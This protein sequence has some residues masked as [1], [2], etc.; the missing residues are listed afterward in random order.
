MPSSFSWLDYSEAE[1]RRALDVADSFK[2]RDTRDELGI[3]TV[4]DAL[5]NILFPGTTTIQTR[6]RYFLFIPWIYLA[7]EEKLRRRPFASKEEVAKAARREEI[8]LI[9]VLLDSDDADGTI[10]AEAGATLKRLPSNI[11]WY[12]MGSWGIRKAEASQDQ[13]HR[14]LATAGA[15]LRIEGRNK[16]DG[17][18]ELRSV[19]NWHPALHSLRPDEFPQKA[20]FTLTADES[21][22]LKE[23][24]KGKGGRNASMLAVLA[25]S[26]K[27]WDDVDFAWEHEVVV[28]NG[29]PKQLEIA[30]THARNFSEIMHGAALLY[31]LMLAKRY[32]ELF[33]VWEEKIE[34]YQGEME[35]WSETMSARKAA[36]LDW[37]RA[38]FWQTISAK[39]TRISP[40]TVTFINAWLD[41]TF[42]CS[43]PGQLASS[44]EAQT[45]LINRER[46]HKP[47][48][49]ARLLDETALRQWSG[50]A[51][52][53][54]LDFRWGVTQRL[55]HDI[56]TPAEGTHA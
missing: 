31:N 23:R 20:S 52:S 46:S 19:H 11:Y 44:G 48:G 45:L 27:N 50:A 51:G 8:A 28:S 32:H 26:D 6:A 16:I 4:R 40:R 37:D 35:K 10:G 54:Q 18:D 56:L 33:T 30:L 1:R 49:M 42:A 3:G 14:I 5:A 9:K 21:E 7:V 41:L 29:L 39:N 13:Y 47:R 53:R 12:G 25:D 24:I 15:P 2:S 36:Y 22:F 55:L 43:T 34:T 17:G 38:H